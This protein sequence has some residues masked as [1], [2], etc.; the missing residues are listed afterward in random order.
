VQDIRIEY[1][2]DTGEIF[3]FLLAQ[4]GDVIAIHFQCLL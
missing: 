3:V 4:A 1:F 2:P